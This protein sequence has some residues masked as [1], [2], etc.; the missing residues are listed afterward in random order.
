MGAEIRSAL[1]RTPIFPGFHTPSRLIRLPESF[2]VL[3]STLLR[4]DCVGN[5]GAIGAVT[6]KVITV[7]ADVRRSLEETNRETYLGGQ[8]RKHRV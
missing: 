7:I 3:N 8:I 1:D 6:Q 2:E 4:G 5:H